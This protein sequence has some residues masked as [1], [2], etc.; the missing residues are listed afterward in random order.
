MYKALRDCGPA[1]SEPWGAFY[2]D[3]SFHPYTKQLEALGFKTSLQLSRRLIEECGV[4]ALSGSAFGED[5]ACFPGG[6]YRLRM[7]TSYQYFKN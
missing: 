2:V 4:A 7:A 1:V 3:P 6:L 5:D